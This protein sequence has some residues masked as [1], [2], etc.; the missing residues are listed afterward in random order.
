MRKLDLYM[1][2]RT[3]NNERAVKGSHCIFAFSS[4]DNVT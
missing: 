3:G 1:V 2:D 4:P